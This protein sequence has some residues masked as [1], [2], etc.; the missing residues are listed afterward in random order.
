MKLLKNNLTQSNQTGSYTNVIVVLTK[1]SSQLPHAKHRLFY[2]V[3]Q[4]G[5]AILLPVQ[6][7]A[8]LLKSVPKLRYQHGL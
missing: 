5:L 4:I 6:L 8:P 2:F 1:P 3:L 7:F